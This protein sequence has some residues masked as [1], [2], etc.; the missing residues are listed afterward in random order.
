MLNYKFEDLK[1]K[2]QSFLKEDIQLYINGSYCNANEGKVFEVLDPST[3]K[4]ITNVHEANH[5]DIDY[6]VDSARAA[7]DNGEW[8]KNGSA[9]K[10]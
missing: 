8:T 7:F 6:A 3:E 9:Y 1:P 2:V 5:V 4:V 10:K